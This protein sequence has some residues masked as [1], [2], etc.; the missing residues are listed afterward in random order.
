MGFPMQAKQVVGLCVIQISLPD[1]TTHPGKLPAVT[2]ILFLLA[3][4][5]IIA[6]V[7][8]CLSTSL[9]K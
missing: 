7:L 3:A 4:C 6:V 1:N 5:K 8:L 2:H 9:Q